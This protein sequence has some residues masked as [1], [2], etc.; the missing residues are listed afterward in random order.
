M[1][2]GA[3]LPFA[4]YAVMLKA[5]RLQS[6]AGYPLRV[7]DYERL[8]SEALRAWKEK[9]RGGE[10]VV[11]GRAAYPHLLRL[12]MAQVEE[13][14]EGQAKADLYYIQVEGY[15]AAAPLRNAVEWAYYV[16]LY[17]PPAKLEKPLWEGPPAPY[18]V[19]PVLF[20]QW[21]EKRDRAFKADAPFLG[22]CATILARGDAMR[23]S[24]LR[25]REW[26]LLLTLWELA[27]EAKEGELKACLQEATSLHALVKR[28]GKRRG[29]R[30]L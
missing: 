13:W 20:Q 15:I 25:V 10:E 5:E 26:P 12:I 30:A 24:L 3:L 28:V 9:L 4:P 16:L 6:P 22:M 18:L 11:K 7:K 21:A 2:E 8:R 19:M 14:G 23:E 29:G 27:K 17:I 1:K